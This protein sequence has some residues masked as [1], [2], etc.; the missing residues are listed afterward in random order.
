MSRRSVQARL[1]RQAAERAAQ[2]SRLNVQAAAFRTA[3][4]D[5][6]ILTGLEAATPM[7]DA[8]GWSR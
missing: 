3:N 4:R 1:D 8:W 2:R 7:A 5:D 6:R